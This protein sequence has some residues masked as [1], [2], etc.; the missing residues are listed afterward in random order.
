MNMKI[1]DRVKV[2]YFGVTIIGVIESFDCSGVTL[3]CDEPFDFRGS[4]RDG[5]WLTWHEFK[6][7][8]LVE[9]GER[10]NCET[11]NGFTYGVRS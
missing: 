2:S 10:I 1:N 5:A 8:E 7:A 4:K 9:A 3:A 6:G 11:H